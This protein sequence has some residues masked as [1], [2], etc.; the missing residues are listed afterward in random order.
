MKI[1]NTVDCLHSNE[2]AGYTTEQTIWHFVQDVA[3]VLIRL[4]E[5]K[6]IHGN[7]TLENVSIDADSFVLAESCKDGNPNDDIWQLGACAYELLTGNIPFGGKGKD[8]QTKISP[9]PSFR[10]SI[11]SAKFTQLVQRCLIYDDNK[12]ITAKE[13]Y[14]IAKDE[15]LHQER[16]HSNIEHLKFKKPQN[17]KIRMKNYGFWPEVMTVLLLLFMF[18]L[19]ARM[20]AQ[21]DDEMQKLIQL[22]TSMRNQSNRQKVL[23]ELLN[24]THWAIMDELKNHTGECMFRD[25]VKMFGMNSIANEIAQREKGIVNVGGRFRD[26]RNPKYPYSFIE[27][28]A[29]A[30]KTISYQV[31]GHTGTQQVAVIP[32]DTKQ[33]YAVS[34]NVGGKE[35]KPTNVKDGITYFTFST[36]GSDH[37]V[38]SISNKNSKNAS[39]VII[40]YNSQQ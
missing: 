18:V 17:R 13:I 20:S 12:R 31:N 7:V 34:F 14:E 39:F 5:N 1:I 10:E 2:I 32:F 3:K 29:K 40:T 35:I 8:G 16:F 36:S 23:K 22:T 27:R 15:L 4:H 37:Y 6:Y 19:P 21:V 30:N 26:S 25:P 28:T 24:D 38:F 33:K 9:L 11:A